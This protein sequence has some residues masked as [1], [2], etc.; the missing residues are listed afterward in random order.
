MLDLE[1]YQIAGRTASEIAASAEG[2][3]REGRLDTGELLPTVRALAKLLGTSPATVN[4]AYRTLRQRGLVVADGRRGTR[5]APRPA[6]RTPPRPPQPSADESLRDLAIGLPDPALLPALVPALQR[7]ELERRLRFSELEANDRQLA[8][9]AGEWFERDGIDGSGI[10]VVGGAFDA[11]VRVLQIQLRP[12][13]RVIV[14]DPTYISILDVLRALGLIAAP[15]PVDDFGLR[16]EP[17]ASALAKGVEAVLIVPRAQNPL[18]AALDEARA[19]DL[20]QVLDRHPDVLVLEDDHAALVSGVPFHSTID[21]NRL[22]WALVRSVSKVLHPDLRLAVMA[23]DKSTIARVEGRQAIGTRWVS[24]ILQALAAELL[25][26]P[27][28]PQTAA[29]AERIYTERRKLLLDALGRHDLE[30]HGRSGL[31]IW[32]PV[33]EEAPVVRALQDAG[34]LVLAGERFRSSTPPG[35]RITIS[36]IQPTEADEIA[37]TIAA[38]EHAGRPRRSY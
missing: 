8:R 12:G 5:V 16:P 2:A 15:V 37:N 13:D 21:P 38:V 10:A 28:F 29:D 1:Q 24:H 32:V 11:I 26:D 34:W 31:N 25:A 33:Y 3:I 4:A 17:F 27:A 20:R 23:G 7:I 19:A 6:L 35:I 9:L 22:R 14:E 30:A 18:G 36:T